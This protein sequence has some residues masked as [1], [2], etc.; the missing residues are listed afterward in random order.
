MADQGKRT[1]I[2]NG[3]DIDGAI[4]SER[5]IVLSGT[6]KGQI[7]APSLEVTQEGSVNGTVKVS[8]FSCKGEVGGEVWAESVELAGRVRDATVIKSKSIDVKLAEGEGAVQ[9]TF[10]NCELQVGDLPVR[11]KE[12]PAAQTSESS[13]KAASDQK[14]EAN[15]VDVV[16]NLMK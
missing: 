8:E 2:E 5:P 13:K 16:S 11:S 6:V 10:G 1:V 9:M 3:T 4:K 7:T 12:K 14:A 15:V